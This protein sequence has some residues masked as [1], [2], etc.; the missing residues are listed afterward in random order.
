VRAASIRTVALAACVVLLAVPARADDISGYVELGYTCATSETEFVGV[1]PSKLDRTSLQRRVNF[2]W[3]RRLF[4]NLLAEAGAYYERTDET[5][6]EAGFERESERSRLRPFARLSLRAPFALGELAWDRNEEKNR[7]GDL[8]G[9]RLTRD[10]W[11]ATASWLPSELPSV[12]LDLTKVDDRDDTRTVEDRAETSARLTSQYEPVQSTRLYYRGSWTRIEDRIDGAEFRTVNHNGQVSFTDSFFDDRWDVGGNWST[13]FRDTRI[14]SRGTGE[15]LI[16]VLPVGGLFALDDSPDEGLLASLPALVDGNT[17]VGTAVNLG[18]VPPAGDDRPRNFGVDLG[19]ERDVNVFRVW[20]DRELPFEISS[21]FSWEIWTSVD[22]RFWSRAAVVPT[23]PFGPFD[24]RFEVRFTNVLARYVKVVVRPLAPTVPDAASYASILVTELE[25]LSSQ[26]TNAFGDR[27]RDTRNLAQANSR[28]RLVRGAELFY[29]TTYSLVAS[30]NGPTSW[31]LSNGIS[32]SHRFNEVWGIGGRFAREDGLDQDR[33]RTAYVYSGSVTA[34]PYET[35][36]H[37]LVLSGFVDD[38]GGF[39]TQNHGVI[40]NTTALVYQ[41]VDLTFLL[42]RS[43]SEALDFTSDADQIGAGATL[44][45]HRTLTVNL[46]YDDRDATISRG[47]VPDEEDRTRSGEAGV[48]YTPFPSVYLFASR[49]KEERTR[50]GDRTVDSFAFSWSP[51]PGGAL[52]VSVSYNETRYSDLDEVGRIFVP[53]VRWNI[54]PRSYLEVA[55][56]AL[57]RESDLGRNDDDILTATLRVG[58]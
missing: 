13:T 56:Q 6:E 32:G 4:P 11:I 16:P 35:L 53:F 23:A 31:I 21:T 38:T 9:L 49:R 58:F 18:L 43:H 54:R 36:R 22:A 3:S 52:Q 44:V 20:V 1:P 12:R 10:T 51:F 26:P 57:S 14:E 28:F 40:L 41:G 30:S 2:R 7:S 46:R 27:R 55:Y 19:I 29:E 48:A 45:P 25:P 34:S 33:D 15:I 17:V 37:S 39:T 5:L 47:G 24:N 8:A 50:E 42:G